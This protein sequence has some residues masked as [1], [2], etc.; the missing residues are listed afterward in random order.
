MDPVL[1]DPVL[2]DPVL[3]D[4]VVLHQHQQHPLCRLKYRLWWYLLL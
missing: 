1:L 4:P 3:L 2:L